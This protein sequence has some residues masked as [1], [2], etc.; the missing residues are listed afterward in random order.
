M[1]SR[2]H[3]AL[4]LLV[5]IPALMLTSCNSERFY[6]ENRSIADGAW[7]IY[8]TISF[9]VEISDTSA[10]Y[11]FYVNVRNDLAYPYSNVFL[12][13]KTTFPDQRYALDT[14]E[15]TLARYDGKWLGSGIG[16]VRFNRFLIQ[17]MVAFRKPGNYTFGFIHAMRSNELKG[18]RDIGLRIE[19]K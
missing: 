14:L 19:K 8:D 10:R 5:S 6:E 12:F 11:N 13:L 18:I 2:V 4:T 1:S 7:N 15:C 16:S 17:E 3:V 9:H